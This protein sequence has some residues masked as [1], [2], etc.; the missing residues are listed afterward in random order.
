M[1]VWLSMRA[2]SRTHWCLRTRRRQSRGNQLPSCTGFCK[3]RK[4]CASS[5]RSK[6]DSWLDL[7]S[8]PICR[9]LRAV[10]MTG[11]VALFEKVLSWGPSASERTLAAVEACE[12]AATSRN[13][14]MMAA[15]IRIARPP[16]SVLKRLAT[17][18]FQ[19]PPSERERQRAKMLED[20]VFRHYCRA[21]ETACTVGFVEGVDMLLNTVRES[22]TD[23]G[24]RQI[25]AQNMA[26][27]TYQALTRGHV[28]V[29]ELLVATAGLRAAHLRQAQVL[30]V[31]LQ[32]VL[33]AGAVN[34]M[35]V[36]LE[37]A[38]VTVADFRDCTIRRQLS[39]SSVAMLKYLRS[40]LGLTTFDFKQLFVGHSVSVATD[41][42]L[43]AAG[44]ERDALLAARY[45]LLEQLRGQAREP[46]C[47]RLAYLLLLSEAVVEDTLRPLLAEPLAQAWGSFGEVTAAYIDRLLAMG[48]FA[49]AATPPTRRPS[50]SDGWNVADFNDVVD[51]LQT[52]AQ[53]ER[54]PAGHVADVCQRDRMDLVLFFWEPCIASAIDRRVAEACLSV[55]R[56]KGARCHCQGEA[57]FRV[58]HKLLR[59]V[60]VF[61]DD[62]LNLVEASEGGGGA[63]GMEDGTADESDDNGGASG[64]SSGDQK[65]GSNDRKPG[66]SERKSSGQSRSKSAS[67]ARASGPAQ[68]SPPPEVRRGWVS[69]Q[70]GRWPLLY[71]RR[72]LVL[73]QASMT[74]GTGTTAKGTV[75]IDALLSVTNTTD[76]AGSSRF[77]G[78]FSVDTRSGRTYRFACTSAADAKAWVAAFTGAIAQQAHTSSCPDGP[79]QRA[80][81]AVAPARPPPPTGRTKDND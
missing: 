11:D 57:R 68:V 80:P 60:A 8:T 18:L 9:A 4:T 66:S 51:A 2:N 35:R 28:A 23:G 54:D 59:V 7:V 41:T 31:V 42:A 78:S 71:Q 16:P 5:R 46:T 1:K 25:D 6:S 17:Q 47:D 22:G 39:C 13:A 77:P 33:T 67:N 81:P 29:L 40:A 30:D 38:N 72:L 45:H 37:Q 12:S 20:T 43:L 50:H 26:Q 52:C 73:S 19:S 58:F 61:T 69:K 65:S 44:L 76:S 79:R 62:E 24:W 55:L 14:Q 56:Q 53:L 49:P 21:F 64:A 74:Y 15:A 48:C 27:S 3:T 70:S 10:V 32:E 63:G 36:L 75:A 34:T